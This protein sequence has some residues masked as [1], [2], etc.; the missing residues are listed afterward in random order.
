MM[1]YVCVCVC[2][3]LLCQYMTRKDL[4]IINRS[5]I[6][7]ISVDAQGF[8]YKLLTSSSFPS[9]KQF[10]NPYTN[11]IIFYKM[12]VADTQEISYQQLCEMQW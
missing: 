12:K 6:I 2:V 5:L 3:Y 10:S 7:L 9:G 1:L 11:V 4:Y 8:H